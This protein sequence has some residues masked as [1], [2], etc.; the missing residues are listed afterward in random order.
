MISVPSGLISGCLSFSFW[1]GVLKCLFVLF[2]GVDLCFP[3]VEVSDRRFYL[4]PVGGA[5][6]V[7]SEPTAIP[8]ICA[9][10]LESVLTGHVCRCPLTAAALEMCVHVLW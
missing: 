8:G 6:A 7:Y 10:P 4:L 2:Q 3:L 9:C 1:S 5:G